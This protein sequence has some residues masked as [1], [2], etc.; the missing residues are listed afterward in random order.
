MSVDLIIFDCD[1]VLVDSEPLSIRVLVNTLAAQ[2]IFVTPD[3][4]FRDYLGRSLATVSA[5]IK[6]SHG[7]PLGPTALEAMRH[8]LFALFQAELKPCPGVADMLT[9][10]DIPFCVASSSMPERIRYSLEITGLLPLFE[11]RIFSASMVANGKPAPDL[12]LHTAQAMGVAPQNCLVI[13][14]S[15]PGIQAAQNA[16]MPVFAYLGGSHIAPAALRPI[17]DALKPV[18]SFDDMQTLPDRI[19]SLQTEEKAS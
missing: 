14:D 18:Q 2:G 11:G 9:Q 10:L 1:G 3:E 17:I 7:V 12:F 4:A 15:P 5:S 16:G 13:E 8:D 19:R 6:D